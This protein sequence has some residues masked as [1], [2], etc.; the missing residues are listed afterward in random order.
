[1][2]FKNSNNEIVLKKATKR[3]LRKEKYLL[4]NDNETCNN[5]KLILDFSYMI[6]NCKNGV[7]V[8]Q[9]TYIVKE[10]WETRKLKNGIYAKSKKKK[11]AKMLREGK[12]ELIS[13]QGLYYRL[14]DLIKTY[15][16][17]IFAAY[18]GG[19]D[20][21]A[22]YNTFDY[23]NKRL[24][25][26][27]NKC[28]RGGE[29]KPLFLNL[30]L[31]DLW[32]YASEFYRKPHFKEWYDK[33]IKELTVSG[34]RK[35]TV[36]I[37]HKYLKDNNLLCETHYGIEDLAIEYEIFMACVWSRPNKMVLLNYKGIYGAYRLAQD[38][39]IKK[40]SRTYKV[41]VKYDLSRD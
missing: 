11:Y 17:T 6:V 14:N 18:N 8:E 5:D 33:N 15:D 7:V 29:D 9:K 13:K 20:L 1:M 36:E 16:I 39:P 24:K 38:K 32:T 26:W 37:M 34:N 22:I 23:T 35:T 27:H 4:L 2:I 21:E 12:A 30:D 28:W 25:Q 40:D 41:N 3:S 31:L 19:F 10:V